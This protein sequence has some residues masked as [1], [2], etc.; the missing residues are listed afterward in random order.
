MYK[1]LLLM[2]AV[3]LNEYTVF[4]FIINHQEECQYSSNIAGCCTSSNNTSKRRSITTSNTEITRRTTTS[5]RRRWRYP[6][7]INSSRRSSSSSSNLNDEGKCKF[8]SKSYW[9]SMYDGIGDRPS[10]SYSWYCG[11]TELEPFWNMLVEEVLVAVEEVDDDNETITSTSTTKGRK[12]KKKEDIKVMVAGIGNDPTPIELYD[13]G[14]TNMVAFDYS[15]SGVDRARQLFG[16]KRMTTNCQL[17][18]ADFCNL[19]IQSSSIDITL[20][21]GTLDAIYI[22]GKD[23][24]YNSIKELTRVTSKN[25]IVVCISAVIPSDVLLN[26]FIVEESSSSSSSSWEI[27]NNGELSFAPNGEATIDLGANLY[28]FRR[29]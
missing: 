28:S 19:P 8:G 21:K 16:M 29:L 1:L 25:G 24:L 18:V 15:K 14:Y 23:V 11:W 13:D 6:T 10:D 20:D 27:I 7:T 4:S 12:K 22:T 2:I 5:R 26:A 3:F 17:L 9:D